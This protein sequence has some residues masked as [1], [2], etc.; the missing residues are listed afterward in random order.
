MSIFRRIRTATA[1]LLLAFAALTL[2]V[3]SH[4]RTIDRVA[5][6]T[7]WVVATGGVDATVVHV[8][9]MAGDTSW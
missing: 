1:C 9:A 2:A 5:G 7:S 3:D 8:D 4:Q 6:D